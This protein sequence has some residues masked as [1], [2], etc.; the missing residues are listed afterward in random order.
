MTQASWIPSSSLPSQ[1]VKSGKTNSV[2]ELN[3]KQQKTASSFLRS[4]SPVNSG[5]GSNRSSANSQRSG[6]NR[7]KPT[8]SVTNKGKNR[9]TIDVGETK[10]AGDRNDKPPPKE[11][12][13]TGTVG[14]ERPESA[15]KVVLTMYDDSL[16]FKKNARVER[17]Q[18]LTHIPSKIESL[19]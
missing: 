4:P 1:I 18:D 12:G 10:Y 5:Q 6:K 14:V 16:I 7:V 13:G 15:H 17:I 11:A 2:S 9:I 8:T 19:Q 3:L